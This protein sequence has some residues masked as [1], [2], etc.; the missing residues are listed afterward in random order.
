VPTDPAAPHAPSW[1]WWVCGALL[2]ATFL[3]YMDR[4]ALAVTVPRL[5]TDHHLH[6]ARVGDLESGFGFAFAAGSLIF[7]LLADRFGPRLLYPL[8]LIGWSVAG[9]AT[10]FAARP[11]VVT[12]LET[13]GDEP[14]AGTF[15]WLLIW[16]TALGFFEAGHWPCALITARRIL[17]PTDRPF[18]NSILQSGASLGAIVIP[19][20]LLLVLRLG[21]GW[22]MV[23]WS[24]GVGGLMWVPVWLMLVRRGDLDA[25]PEP[26]PDA[27]APPPLPRGEFVRRLVV[28]GVTVSCLTVSWQFLR[29]WLPLFLQG[30]HGYS[31]EA[32]AGITS[33]YYI[34]SDVGCIAAGALVLWLAKTGAGLHAARVLT[35]AA[36]TLLTAAAAA[37]PWAGAGWAMV[38]LLMVAGAGILGLHPIYYALSQELPA[39]RMGVLSGGLAAAG[40]V[41]SAV[42]QHTIG[43]HI[44]AAESYDLGLVIAGLA[45]LAALVVLAAL[46][47]PAPPQ[48]PR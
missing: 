41:V 27:P 44:K 20:Y 23:F 33:G 22:E 47:R 10:G 2:L 21:G 26:A 19:L 15:R 29:A 16:R 45:P 42:N 5:K 34:A 11:E 48:P 13:P 7:G 1:K 46:W 36:F 37:V 25:H 35:F 30:Y 38:A 12:G 18:G 32:T 8:V 24:V 6:E 4:Q 43:H 40:W 39:K 9:V 14:G 28:L 31:Q 3:N 17:A